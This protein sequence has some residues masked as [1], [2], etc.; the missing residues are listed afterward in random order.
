MSKPSAEKNKRRAKRAEKERK[1]AE[2]AEERWA[3]ADKRRKAMLEAAKLKREQEWE[4]GRPEREARARKADE[5]NRLLAEKRAAERAAWKEL[6]PEQVVE[7]T[8]EVRVV[9]ADVPKRKVRQIGGGM[10]MLLPLLMAV[11]GDVSY[12]EKR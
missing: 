5:E 2:G 10:M 3:E 8:G 12:P 11:G 9:P 1:K 4:A 7:P 6:N